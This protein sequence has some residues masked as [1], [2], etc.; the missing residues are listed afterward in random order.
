MLSE[1]GLMNTMFR[2][3]AFLVL[4]VL[5][6]SSTHA[7]VIVSPTSVC[8]APLP[9]GI[10]LPGPLAGED[11]GPPYEV[12]R[13]V[14]AN[15]FP[16]PYQ[17]LLGLLVFGVAANQSITAHLWLEYIGG[18]GQVYDSPLTV[19]FFALLNERF[20]PI[21]ED[22]NLYRE[23]VIPYREPFVLDF[24]VPPLTDDGIYDLVIIAVPNPEV[25]TRDGDYSSELAI[26]SNRMTLVV[27]DPMEVTASVRD[28]RSARVGIP[29]PDDPPMPAGAN[30]ISVGFDLFTDEFKP[31]GEPFAPLES[32]TFNVELGQTQYFTDYSFRS[33]LES[34]STDYAL[35]VFDD[36]LPVSINESAETVL[37][38]KMLSG[39]SFA[40]HAV[41]FT[42]PPTGVKDL[43]AVR[44]DFPGTPLCQYIDGGG[45]RLYGL[46]MGV[47]VD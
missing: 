47:S 17:S 10:G 14:R 13:G 24:Q 5:S 25:P 8:P 39:D 37:Y 31:F 34:K 6:L 27:G 43:I 41:S 19:R 22:E 36:Y 3:C 33:T 30:R 35:I 4:A 28:Y 21:N 42:A 38:A 9:T 12:D 7:Q 18:Y 45:V 40:E 26:F 1:I 46:R 20:L 32:V 15:F 11:A 44:I 16:E 29:M 2:K 23:V